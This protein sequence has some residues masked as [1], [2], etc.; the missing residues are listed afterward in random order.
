MNIIQTL[1]TAKSKRWAFIKFST[2]PWTILSQ[3]STVMSVKAT[4]AFEAEICVQPVA[5]LFVAIMILI[6]AA[7][8]HTGNWGVGSGWSRG[9]PS[10][11][12]CTNTHA[13][14]R[15]LVLCIPTTNLIVPTACL[16]TIPPQLCNKVVP[17]TTILTLSIGVTGL[18]VV[19]PFTSLRS[20]KMILELSGLILA[21]HFTSASRGLYIIEL[22]GP[23]RNQTW[24]FIV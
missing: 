2:A 16:G 21:H 15:I 14:N 5:W 22:F 13:C 9:V 11:R 1:S 10:S 4:V 8:I 23:G 17:P 18:V 12:W 7:S 19:K 3:W 20:I 24:T 6:G